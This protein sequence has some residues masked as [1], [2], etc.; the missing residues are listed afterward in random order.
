MLYDEWLDIL[1]SFTYVHIKYLF[2]R[3]FVADCASWYE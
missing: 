2:S 3:N 1:M